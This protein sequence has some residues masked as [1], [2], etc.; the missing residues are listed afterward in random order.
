MGGWF[1]AGDLIQGATGGQSPQKN[2]NFFSKTKSSH[3]DIKSQEVSTNYEHLFGCDKRLKSV[4]SIW[5]PSWEIGLKKYIF[6]FFP[7]PTSPL[8]S[9]QINDKLDKEKD[10]AF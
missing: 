8:P 10:A 3:I 5:G 2:F 1:L 4:G 9:G 7:F 6:F